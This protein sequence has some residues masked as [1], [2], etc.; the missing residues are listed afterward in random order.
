MSAVQFM[1]MLFGKLP[2]FFADEDELRAIWSA[3]DTRAGLLT[4]LAEAGFGQDQMAEMQKIV[5]AENSDL[6][7]VLSHIAWART[8]VTRV[9]RAAHARQEISTRFTGKQQAFLDFVLSHY[10]T[11]GVREL[12]REKLTP[13]LKLKYRNAISDAISELGRPEEIG[14]LFAGFQKYLYERESR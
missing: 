14:H 6:F 10:V 12:D 13:L 3:P 4:G 11:E 1:E 8:P 5:N 2:R 7:D 9:D